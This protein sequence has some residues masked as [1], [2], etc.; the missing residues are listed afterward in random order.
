MDGTVFIHT[1]EKQL[2]GAIVS[3]HSMRR[4]SRRPADFEVR[5]IECKDHPF[6]QA[7]EGQAFLRDGTTRIWNND[8]LQSFTP[9]RFMPPALMGFQGR[10][11]V[12][13]PDVFAVGDV[14]ELL[15]RDMHGMAILC[16]ERPGF[17]HYASSVM[18][19]DCARLEHWRCEAEFEELFA[20]RRDYT[21][22]IS[23]HGE[24]PATIG[25]LEPEWNDFDVMTPR[26][27]LLHTTKRR[28][29]P[30]KTGLPVDFTPSAR[31][32][33]RSLGGRLRRM[34]RSLK[35]KRRPD[36]VYEPHPVPAV[37]EFFFRLLAECLDLG[38]VTEALLKDHMARDYIRHDA[39][40]RVA[41][42]RRRAAA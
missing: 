29:Q 32:L 37:E 8:D 30:W 1:N 33:N 2:V 19:L 13:D 21:D 17:K 38:L 39:F 12:T 26:T 16:R 42:V 20:M 27:R 34:A 14:H 4:N 5:I 35:G 28:T 15:T 7:H 25:L 40:D 23:L 18:L 41:Q 6:L 11:I 24:S 10:A 31:H 3:G 36:E 22:W 9:L